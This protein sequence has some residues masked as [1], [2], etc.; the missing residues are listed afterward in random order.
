M[1]FLDI[2][3]QKSKIFVN[4]SKND[5]KSKNNYGKV[6]ISRIGNNLRIQLRIIEDG[7]KSNRTYV[8][9]LFNS[10]EEK[11]KGRDNK[12]KDQY[13]NGLERKKGM[14]NVRDAANSL[15]KL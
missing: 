5:L 11:S 6:K 7:L 2:K 10:Q 1:I 9:F 13:I 15:V 4:K 12:D 14:S 3:M 8:F